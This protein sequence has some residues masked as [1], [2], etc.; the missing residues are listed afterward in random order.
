MM[1]D[2]IEVEVNLIASNKTKQRNETRR[3]KEED[4]QAST[5]QSS[6]NAKFNM[7]MKTMEK[8]MDKLSTDDKNQMKN[9]NEPQVRNPNFRRQQGPLVPQVM[10]MGQRNPN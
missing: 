6:S 9:Q 2:A 1:D 3:A 8:L 10:P 4:P 7:M 5:S